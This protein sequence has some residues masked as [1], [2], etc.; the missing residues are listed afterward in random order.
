[1][2]GLA[3]WWWQSDHYEWL[4]QY[5]ATRGLRPLIQSMMALSTVTLSSITLAMTLW[6]P[7]GAH[8]VFGDA[9]ALLAVVVC[10]VLAAMW[11]LRWPSRRQSVGY[12]VTT[13]I[14]TAMVC[15]SYSDRLFGLLGCMTFA[16]LG[17][18]IAFFHT[19]R[20]L[21]VNLA[22]AASTALTLTILLAAS[23][24]VVRAVCAF[25]EVLVALGSV[26]FA[27][28]VLVKRLA[29]DVGHSEVDPLCGL[30]N[31]RGFYAATH[32]LL[33]R[34]LGLRTYLGMAM[35]DLDNFKQLNDS[36]GHAAG[37]Q[38]LNEVG[39]TLRE[40]CR[41]TSIIGRVGGEEFLI[42]D[43]APTTTL[44]EM[45][46]RVRQAIANSPHPIT[47]SI[48]IVST[49]LDGMAEHDHHRILNKLISAADAAM[50]EAKKA[51][52]NQIRSAQAP[53]NH[54]DA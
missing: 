3:G 9:S 40:N 11:A 33:A 35:I 4:S 5:L 27:S 32:R 26:P 47:A 25:L 53:F 13:V 16:I 2:T 1:M 17:G 45:A 43:I 51:G 29:A 22:V 42:V 14:C 31:R 19:T 23:G 8:R 6:S 50:Y 30:L 12:A 39:R 41:S 20:L 28:S 54:A 34:S 38:A 52:G 15:V 18:Y 44:T 36:Q 21:V 24:D 46:E 37:D 49:R 48:G 7:G 10:M